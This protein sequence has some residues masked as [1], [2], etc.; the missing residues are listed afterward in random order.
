MTASGGREN[1]WLRHGWGVRVST[2]EELLNMVTSIALLESKRSYAWRGQSNADWGI[3]SSLSRSLNATNDPTEDRIRAREVEVLAE[4]R[5]W[6]ISRELGNSATD[7]H[8]LSTLQHHGVPT[9][10]I[11]VT[12]NPMTAI[13]F[14]TQPNVDKYGRETSGVLFAF[15]V[16]SM[17]WHHTFQ[18]GQPPT[19]GDLSY[20]LSWS[21]ISALEESESNRNSFRLYS[22]LPDER[23]KAQEGYFLASSTPTK[24][25][26]PGVEGLY[27]K[28]S[29]PGAADL[30]LMKFTFGRGRGRPTKLPFCA[31]VISA[32]VKKQMREPLK[33]TYN[34]RPRVL[35]PDIDGFREALPDL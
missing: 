33:N 21:L 18:H 31:I 26:I 14:A 10:L 34:R 23:M 17:P 30:E 22:A 29:P 12:A 32:R 15:D 8:M 25:S 16:T 35:F 7:L 19:M 28:G 24:P 1:H 2:R 6:G 5:K 9:R 11:D 4:S 3:S 27:L 13:W 20:P